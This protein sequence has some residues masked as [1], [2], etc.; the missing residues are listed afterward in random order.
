VFR[1]KHF[2]VV[3]SARVTLLERAVANGLSVCLSVTLVIRASVSGANY[4]I[5][6]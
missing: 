5:F 6:S 4:G 1:I 2:S 3:S